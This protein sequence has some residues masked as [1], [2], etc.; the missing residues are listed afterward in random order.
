VAHLE[1]HQLV[2]SGVDIV[3]DLRPETVDHAPLLRRTQTSE[4]KLEERQNVLGA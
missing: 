4:P 2:E 1:R 3:G